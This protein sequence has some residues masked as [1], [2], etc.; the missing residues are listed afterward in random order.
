MT[1]DPVLAVFGH[2]TLW[3]VADRR[4]SY[5]HHGRR[6]TDESGMK[7]ATLDA[8]DGACV[9]AYAGLGATARGMQ[10][11]DWMANVL[12]GRG[13]LTLEQSLGALSD[14]ASSELPRHLRTTP[15]GVHFIVAPAFVRDVGRRL[16]AITN[17]IEPGSRKH[18]Y[19]YEDVRFRPDPSS[20]A[21]RIAGAGTGGMYLSRLEGCLRPLL[22]AIKA[23][24][25]G[26]VSELVV[27]R[28]LAKLNLLAHKGLGDGSVGPRCVVIWR[29]RIGGG[30][31]LFYSGTDTDPESAEIP[32]VAAGWDLRFLLPILAEP[33]QAHI[34]KHGLEFEASTYQFDEDETARR[35]DEMPRAPD[36][37]LR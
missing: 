36:E 4:L 28:E 3:V 29:K 6:W 18:F 21:P 17:Y 35:I 24:D 34:A 19:R 13:D 31:Q 1:R 27:A 11:S 2:E 23:N 30:A 15:A 10:P 20:P 25:R 33:L 5:S 16:Y 37:G 26:K 32:A 9:L 8:V 12:R 14:A 22:R 7:I